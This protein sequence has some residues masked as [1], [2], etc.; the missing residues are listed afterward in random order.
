MLDFKTIHGIKCCRAAL[1]HTQTVRG[2]AGTPAVGQEFCHCPDNASG[3]G[4]VCD[5]EAGVFAG[6]MAAWS[7]GQRRNPQ[8]TVVLLLKH[9]LST[10]QVWV[11]FLLWK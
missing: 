2:C 6:S 9:E 4:M 5:A 8:Q 11:P 10:S 3:F 1:P 7:A